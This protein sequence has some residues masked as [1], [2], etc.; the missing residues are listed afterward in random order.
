VIRLATWLQVVGWG[1]AAWD[2]LTPGRS[3]L[4]ALPAVLGASL[5]SCYLDARGVS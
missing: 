4:V 5:C 2:V 1:S 3:L